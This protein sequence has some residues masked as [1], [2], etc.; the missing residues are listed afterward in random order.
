[1]KKI[2]I[3]ESQ[4]KKLVVNE[5]L[6]KNLGDKIK[7]GVQNVVDKVKGGSPDAASPQKKSGRD[8]DQ[9]KAEWSKINQDMNNMTGFG[10][11]IGQNLNAAMTQAQMAARVAILKK[12][13][14]QRAT[15]SSYVIDEA[16][17]QL[18]NGNYHYMVL[19][20]LDDRQMNEEV[21]RIKAVMGIHENEEIIV[22]NDKLK[23]FEADADRMMKNRADEITRLEKHNEF[24]K[25]R[26]ADFKG[27]DV[28]KNYALELIKSNEKQ[29]DDLHKASTKEEIV[30]YYIQQYK[31][32]EQQRIATQKYND[33][34]AEMAKTGKI[35]KEQIIGVFV[36][37]LEGGS[38]YWYYILD[39]PNQ[40]RTIMNDEKLAFSEA[41]G[42]FV[43]R[44]GRLP[45][46]DAEEVDEMGDDGSD[47]PEP[48]GTIDMDNLLDAISIMKKDYPEQYVNIIMDEYDADDADIFFQIAT[49]GEITFG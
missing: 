34:R 11:A 1:M 10:E 14:T 29:I 16:T 42:E 20:K 23:S 41:C 28:G 27:D 26:L 13:K 24:I 30:N 8:L 17:F 46:Y 21:S 7:S 18:E 33:E 45:I 38:N 22:P 44:G 2:K 32:G 36:T 31:M 43:L 15:I 12:M 40:L 9:L 37:A 5:Q 4:L 6:L 47:K 3:T 35:T 19:I 39:V 25:N 48:L 49:M